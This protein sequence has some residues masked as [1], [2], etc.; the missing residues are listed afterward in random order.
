M[1]KALKV[2]G[3]LFAA[4]ILVLV[5]FV[6][7]RQN[8]K[9]DDTPFPDIA[10]S[11]DSVVIERG[12]YI[13]R[14]MAPCAACHSDPAQR[15]AYNS[16]EEV[17]LSGGFVFDIPP[18][19]FY[20]RNLTADSAT[21]IGAM[22]D[23][24]VARA[25][26]HGVGSDGRALLPFMEM[27]G[28]ADDDLLAVVS[29][30]R[31]MPAVRHEVPMHRWTVLGK[32]LKATMLAKPIGPSSTPP[33]KAP[34]GTSVES[35]R[36]I[37]ESVALCWACHT[38]RSQA[39]GELIGPRLGGGTGMVESDD[40]GRSW[41]AP[42]ITSDAET[43]RLG[44]LTEDQ[45]VARFRQGRIIPGS[46]MPWQAFSKL[47]EDDLRSVYQYLK[48]LPPVKNDVGP[49]FVNIGTTK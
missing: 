32:V 34:H 15:A 5:I 18:G 30:L 33:A 40:P 29:Y 16:G 46:P 8:L 23:A 48:S 10:A 38:Q 35:G 21:G 25:L 14:T 24:A 7:A 36:Y 27:Q 9:Y 22:S 26:R 3:G 17:A 43:G 31:T 1:K 28:L 37:V 42:N 12:H 49:A 47:R 44:K 20:V 19:K 13:V 45:F 11:K 6:A 41:S 2:L 4:L 39:T